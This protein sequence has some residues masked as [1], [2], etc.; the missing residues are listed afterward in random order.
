MFGLNGASLATYNT[1]SVHILFSWK[2][3]RISTEL[4]HPIKDILVVSK[5]NNIGNQAIWIKPLNWKK[6]KL[7]RVGGGERHISVCLPDF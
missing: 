4:V 1:R 6:T 5:S 2:E 3:E 7:E